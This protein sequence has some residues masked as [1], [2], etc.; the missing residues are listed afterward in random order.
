[1]PSQGD[2]KRGITGGFHKGEIYIFRIKALQNL[3]EKQ[4]DTPW[5]NGPY[6]SDSSTFIFNVK[7]N[8]TDCFSVLA[9][10]GVKVGDWL[11]YTCTCNVACPATEIENLKLTLTSTTTCWIEEVQFFK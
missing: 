9:R 7:N 3:V 5:L 11:E 8:G 10:D 6:I 1:M 4:K 2:L